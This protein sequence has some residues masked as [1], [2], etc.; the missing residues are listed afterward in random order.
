MSLTLNLGHIDSRIV[1]KIKMSLEINRPCYEVDFTSKSVSKQLDD[2]LLPTLKFY[3]KKAK[4]NAHLQS[5]QP[6][7]LFK[8]MSQALALMLTTPKLI[9]PKTAKQSK[10]S[11]FFSKLFSYSTA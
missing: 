3:H 1:A 2:I 9:L 11:L 5:H 7:Q 6:E 4:K 10:P 8:V